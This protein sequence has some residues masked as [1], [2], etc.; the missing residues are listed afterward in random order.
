M[1]RLRQLMLFS[2]TALA[3]AAFAVPTATAEA[4]VPA[5][6]VGLVTDDVFA[7]T[8]EY[9]TQTL[10]EQKAL[11]VGLIRR[12]FD[13]ATIELAPGNYD[14]SAYDGYVAAT[15]QQGI[16]ILPVLF[17]P[18][19][20]KSSKPAVGAKHGTYFPKNAADL[21]AFGRAVAL[22]YGPN[23][24]F[25]AERPDVPKVPITAYQ[26]W[27]EPNI[28]AYAPPTPSARKYVALLKATRTGIRSA[29]PKAE[30]VT[31]GLPDSR[32]SKP[33][34]YRF[35]A[36]MYKAG[37]K[38]KFNTLAINPYAR[39][40]KDM[41]SKLKRIRK[42]MRKAGDRRSRIWLTE[43][44][45]SDVG[46]AGA[47]RVGATGQASRIKQTLP[48]LG[49]ARRS[50]NLRGVVYFAWR[51]GLP[52]A[53]RF[54]DFWGLHTGLLRNDGSHKPA[55]AAFKQAVAGL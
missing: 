37:A 24:S 13:W 53:P 39:T 17:N 46:P 45:W 22:R 9:R 3:A 49:K 1:R 16:R 25:W 48:A 33:D 38:G 4:A 18:P 10:G 12:T 29:D 2:A 36:A 19:A 43:I 14:F 42:I 20:F 34:L 32:L 31:A 30:I 47:F 7:G 52:Y 27:N 11:G 28:A 40:T 51:D 15:A 50:L 54:R 23:G 41:L 26:V 55:L 5:D 21:G 35:V 6:F 44:G 8:P